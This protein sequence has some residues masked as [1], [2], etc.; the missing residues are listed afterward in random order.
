MFSSRVPRM[1]ETERQALE[2][3]TVWFEGSLFAGRPDF[4]RLLDLPWPTLTPRERAF[5]DGPVETVCGMV[6]DWRLAQTRELPTEVWEYLKR[7]RFFGLAIPEAHGGLGFS[8]LAQ[9][10][11]FGKLASKSLALS[12]VVLI[13]NSV[14]PGELLLEYGTPEQQALLARLGKHRMGKACLYFNR[15]AD[16]DIKVLEQLVRGSLAQL[17][18][19]YG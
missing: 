9:S 15:L 17:K 2:A 12:A 3:G 18:S 11:V 19:R 6:D 5:L 8:T 4:R 13:P 10:T 7:E 16:I 1:S 14:G